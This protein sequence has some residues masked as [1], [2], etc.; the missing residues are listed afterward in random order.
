[1]NPPVILDIEASGFGAGSYP[2]EIGYV[3]S[4][5]ATWCSLVRPQSDWVHWDKKAAQLH[6]ITRECLMTAGKEPA[7]IVKHLNRLFSGKVIYS[8]AWLHDFVW[9]NTLCEAA[10][11]IPL[12]KLEDLRYRLSKQQQEYW[13][14][15]KQALL[16][17]KSTNRHRASVDAKFLQQTWIK[18]MEMSESI[19]D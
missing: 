6:G 16:S 17:E 2:I 8:D 18:T 19:S 10:D 7:D 13:H 14:I 15:A 1:M 9:L 3:D 4:H 12:F 5:G 11:I